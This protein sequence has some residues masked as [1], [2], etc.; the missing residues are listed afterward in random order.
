MS[1]EYAE[2]KIKKALDLSKGNEGK[3]RQ[4]IIAWAAEDEILLYALAKPHLS[5]IVA[6]QVERVASGRADTAR[7]GV[8]LSK[9]TVSDTSDKPKTG[10]KDSFGMELLKAVAA[11]DATVFGLEDSGVPRKRAPASQAHVDALKAMAAK[12]KHT[13]K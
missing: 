3:A 12:S 13:K 8:K 1:L 9:K 7:F 4:K 11:A 2:N 6:Y 5:G 10:K